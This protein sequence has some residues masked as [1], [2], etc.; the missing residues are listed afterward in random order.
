MHLAFS[1]TRRNGTRKRGMTRLSWV[2]AGGSQAF[3]LLQG[4]PV[5]TIDGRRLGYVDGLMVDALSHKPRYITLNSRKRHTAAL[6]IPW[7]SLYFDSTLAHLVF[8]TYGD[9]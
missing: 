8:Y 5:V 9:V 6:A 3:Q 4:C 7:H 1:G 2:S